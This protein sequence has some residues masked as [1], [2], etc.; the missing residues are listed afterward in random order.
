[1]LAIKLHYLEKQRRA[2]MERLNATAAAHETVRSELYDLLHEQ[3]A[4][5][6]ANLDEFMGLHEWTVDDVNMDN[7]DIFIELSAP[8]QLGITDYAVGSYHTN[9]TYFY[10]QTDRR[11]PAFIYC[12]IT[13]YGGD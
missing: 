12:D 2:V 6:I 1:M 9:N 7:G 4:T 10:V 8:N 11:Y 13:I 3:D 5:L